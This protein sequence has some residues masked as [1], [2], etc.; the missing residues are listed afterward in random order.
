MQKTIDVLYNQYIRFPE[1]ENYMKRFISMATAILA[2]SL[3][4]VSCAGTPDIVREKGKTYTLTVLHTNDSHGTVLPNGGQAGL[5]ERAT[6]INS[7]RAT[8]KNVLLLD[9]G[10]INTGSALS[11]MFG[12]EIDIKAYNMMKYDAMTFGNHEFDKDLAFLEGQM[13]QADFP[14]LASNILRKDGN[15]LGKPYII[16]N[17]EGFR[18]GIFGITTLRTLTIANPDKSLRFLDEITAGNAM[19]NELRTK[20]KCDIIIALTHLGLTEEVK[21]QTT[22]EIFAQNVPGIDL[23][24]DGH[25]HTALTEVKYSGSTPIVSANEWGKFVGD[26]KFEIVDGKIVSFVWKPVQINT[27]DAKTYTADPAI[28]AMIAPYKEKADL[29]MKEIVAETSDLFEFGDRLSRKKEIALGD[30]VNDGTVWYVK[31]ILRKDVDFAFT[32]GGNIRAELAKGPITREQIT[33]VLPF[34]NWIYLTKMKGSDVIAL[35]DF[36]ASVKQGAGAWAQVSSEVRYTID[37]TANPDKGILKDLT[38][39]GKPVD[40]NAVYTFATNDYLMG[41]GDGYVVLK[42]NVEAYNTSTTLR[43]AIITYA[44]TKKT[45]TPATDGRITIIGGMTIK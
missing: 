16:K 13:K 39:K 5:A 36:I 43:D 15:Y 25:S 3:L 14:F 20:E 45:L 41:G 19:V 2:A 1:K 21:G 27:K 12:G 10:D 29:T 26:G 32:N 4:I 24:I 11:N 9:A 35:F 30:M 7:V 31:E 22:S 6:F 18:V 8:E 42:N 23:I 44:Q 37:Y 38:I 28:V 34:D 33:T 40:P 17:Y